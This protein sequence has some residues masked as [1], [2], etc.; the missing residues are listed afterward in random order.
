MF[1]AINPQ[2]IVNGMIRRHCYGLNFSTASPHKYF[3]IVG[4]DKG[5][6]KY[7]LYDENHSISISR[8]IE[9]SLKEKLP[10][11]KMADDY[12]EHIKAVKMQ[13]MNAILNASPRFFEELVLELLMKMGY[14]YDGGSGKLTR[15]CKDGGIDGIIEE[16]KLGLDKIYIQAKRY[17][18]GNKVSPDEV[19][20]FAF[21]MGEQNVKKGVFIT[22][23]HFVKTVIDTF[24]KPVEGKTIR[25][26][27][28]DELMDFLI[29]YEIGV[30][31]VKSYRTFSLDENYFN[32]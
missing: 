5:K 31:S 26:I 10:E 19:K 2:G 22:T 18:M 16:D 27:D 23:S 20:S 17:N 14:G 9:S 30:N 7:S 3:A 12:N 13:L 8:S 4:N 11:E 1:N 32:I 21:A 28:G 29:K 25:L 6:T 15:Y 24:S